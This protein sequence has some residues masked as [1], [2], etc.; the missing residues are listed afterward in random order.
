M[1]RGAFAKLDAK[2]AAAEAVEAATNG[3]PAKL[4]F[5]AE[6]EGFNLHAGVHIAAGDDMGR[7]RLFRYGSRPALALDRF[8]RLPDGRIAYRV[9]SA[10]A[11]RAKHRV[12]TP[13][14][15]LARIGALAPAALSAGPL[16]RRSGASLVLAK[17]DRSPAARTEALPSG[18][19][20]G[21]RRQVARRHGSSDASTCCFS[22]RLRLGE[23][24]VHGHADGSWRA[25]VRH[26][27]SA[28]SGTAAIDEAC[29]RS[30]RADP[31]GPE[32]SGRRALESAHGRAALRCDSTPPVVATSPANVRHGRRAMPEVPREAAT[33]PEH[34]RCLPSRTPSS[35]GSAYRA[36]RRPRHA[37]ATQPTTTSATIAMA[38]ADARRPP[39]PRC[40]LDELT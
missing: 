37:R 22:A 11:G 40:A 2:D 13:L 28:R 34:H 23:L 4:R 3:G 20:E 8:R 9:K 31:S 19:T 25:P 26:A 24:A 32:H 33:H 21:M 38:E 16:S 39:G 10:R 30:P 12:M 5:A 35:S 27:A 1:Q 7:E 17:R 18:E 36:T 6:H 14:E 15:L 29:S